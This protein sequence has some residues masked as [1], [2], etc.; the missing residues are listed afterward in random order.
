MCL[1]KWPKSILKL[2]S[3]HMLVF[4]TI[5]AI[6]TRENHILDTKTVILCITVQKL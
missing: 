3:C 5:N 4:N 1:P 6:L 2:Y